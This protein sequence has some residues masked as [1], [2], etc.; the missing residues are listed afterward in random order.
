MTLTT[1]HRRPVNPGSDLVPAH[2]AVVRAVLTDLDG[3]VLILLPA[4][5]GRYWHLPGGKV[6]VGESP[7]AACRRELVE[8]IGVDVPVGELLVSAWNPDPVLAEQ[9]WLSYLFDAGVHGADQLGQRLVLQHS[10][11]RDWQWAAPGEAMTLLEP[12][13]ARL[14]LAARSNT[15]YLEYTP[16]ELRQR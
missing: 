15:R 10:E 8:E 13:L 2:R 7:Q 4:K 9:D 12:G 5:P 14:L 11:I 16:Q 6:E 3:R 1:R